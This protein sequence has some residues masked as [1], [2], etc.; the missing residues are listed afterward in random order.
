MN[1]LTGQTS[2]EGQCRLSTCSRLAVPRCPTHT[3]ASLRAP[4]FPH[5]CPP[6]DLAFLPV[7]PPVSHSPETWP[8]GSSH[9]VSPQLPV[10]SVQG[11]L[12][13][14]LFCV[15]FPGSLH[16]TTHGQRWLPILQRRD[17]STHT[18]GKRQPRGL[19]SGVCATKSSGASTAMLS[20][21]PFTTGVLPPGLPLTVQ[22]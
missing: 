10:L 18:A 21:S 7:T 9:P 11:L 5:T 14:Q 16:M 12:E 17:F 2:P 1:T 8:P 3:P 19:R 22:L 15:S 20:S 13:G 4:S 6:A